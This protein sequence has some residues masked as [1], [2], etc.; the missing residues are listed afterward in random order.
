MKILINALYLSW[1]VN[2][3]TETYFH[4]I[5]K[6]LYLENR[7]KEAKF[8]LLCVSPPFWFDGNKPWFRIVTKPTLTS[9]IRRILYEQVAIPLLYSD[10]RVF[11]PGYVGILFHLGH[12][13]TTIHDAYAW[14]FPSEAGK[15]RSLYW[16]FFIST[17]LQLGY[18]AI[19]VSK[20][21]QKDL[22]VNRR[23]GASSNLSTIH[24]SGCHIKNFEPDFNTLE[25]H[26]LTPGEFFF[27]VGMF[28]EIKNPKRI[29]QAY[30]LYR[31]KCAGEPKQLVF[32]GHSRS[33]FAK[34]IIE[35][36][37]NSEG[38]KCIGRITD[39]EVS[40]LY[41]SASAF[42]FTTLYEGFGIPILE[43]QELGCPV[44]TSNTGSMPEIAG[45]NGALFAS[46]QSIDE[47]ADRMLLLDKKEVREML[48]TNGLENSKLFSWSRARAETLKVIMGD[49]P[50]EEST[51]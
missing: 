37:N 1:G 22:E 41:R 8:T 39:D 28:K 5:V 6:E 2:G 11:N 36:G 9:Q 25:K 38:V 45:Q 30:N 16:R 29:I 17:Y 34:S 4:N 42:I 20:N 44:L 21:T 19:S 14:L 10:Y 27:S 40:A 31:K 15:L 18:K 49:S 7:H 46:P 24:E 32:A 23:A 3:G 13:V 50:R 48:T 26:N 12:Q 51:I 43:A 47:I 33:E 35:L